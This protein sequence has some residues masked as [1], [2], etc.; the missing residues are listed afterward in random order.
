MNYLHEKHLS[1]LWTPGTVFERDFMTRVAVPK[2]VPL[3][4]EWNGQPVTTIFCHRAIAATLP[5][6]LAAWRN[7]FNEK[8]WLLQGLD[9][10]AGCYN[11][12]LKRG[13]STPSTHAYG[14]AF[15]V[16]S[17]GNPFRVRSTTFA[18]LVFEIARQHGFFP[19]FQAWGHD[20]MHFQAVVPYRSLPGEWPAPK[21]LTNH[22]WP[23]T[24]KAFLTVEP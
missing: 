6:L 24:A 11:N 2:G 3:V 4:T 20:A 17:A 18:P 22:A 12:R 21:L 5:A 14:L 8:D 23:H 13:G 19:G 7:A 16:F 1:K 15:D 9:K 10:W